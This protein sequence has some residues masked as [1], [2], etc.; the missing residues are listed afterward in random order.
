MKLRKRIK[1]LERAILALDK[2]V[3]QIEKKKV[4]DP[5]KIGF[6]ILYELSNPDHEETYNE[7][8]CPEET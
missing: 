1:N 7:D 3:K 2:R 5:K 8:I 6:D 4:S